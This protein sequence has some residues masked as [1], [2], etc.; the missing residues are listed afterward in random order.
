MIFVNEKTP[1]N[2]PHRDFDIEFRLYGSNRSK[3]PSSR[4]LQSCYLQR[5]NPQL[6]KG[7]GLYE[8]EHKK[9]MF[10]S[11][12]KFMEGYFT[13]SELE[14]YVKK[15]QEGEDFMNPL[16]TMHLY[17]RLQSC[18]L[19]ADYVWTGKTEKEFKRQENEPNEQLVKQVECL[20]YPV[21]L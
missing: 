21:Q 6:Q 13:A 14:I 3:I 9:D 8:T 1:S 11:L 17:Y 20:L 2:L 18:I 19:D 4:Y 12:Y 16:Y 7:E 15:I 10:M 5:T